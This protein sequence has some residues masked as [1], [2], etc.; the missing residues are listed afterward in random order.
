M[1]APGEPHDLVEHVHDD[2]S[3]TPQEQSVLGA[4]VDAIDWQFDWL[5]CDLHELTAGESAVVV[6]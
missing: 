1:A 6:G 2:Q 5:A 3:M 4:Q